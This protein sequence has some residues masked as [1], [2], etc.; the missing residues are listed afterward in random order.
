MNLTRRALLRR[1]AGAAG[2]SAA[3]LLYAGHPSFARGLGQPPE[4]F[5]LPVGDLDGVSPVLV[6]ARPFVL[7]GVSWH[8]PA[9]AGIELRS[10]PVGGR[11]S[12]WVSATARGHDGDG[13]PSRPGQFGEP[14]WTGV[15]DAIQVRSDRPVDGLIVHCVAP[16]RRSVWEAAASSE[17][18]I[19]GIGREPLARPTLPTAGGQPPIIARSAWAGN[20]GPAFPPV[21]GA[22]HLAFVHHTVNPNGYAAADVPAMLLAIYQFHR[23]VRGWNDIGYNFLIDAYGRVWEGRAGGID[24]PVIG[25]QAGGYNLESTGVAMLGTFDSVLPSVVAQATLAQL[26]SWKLSLH[27]APV[28]GRVTV[29][30]DPTDAFYTPFAPGALVALPRIAGHRDGCSTGCPGNALYAHL[31]TIRT[32]ARTLTRQASALTLAG[33]GGARTAANDLALAGVTV[34]AGKPLSVS[35]RLVALAGEPLAT[36]PI[37]VQSITVDSAGVA[38]DRTVAQ[39]Q[40]AIDGTWS[41]T[42]MPTENLLLRAVHPV[43]PASVSA[44]LSVGVQPALTLTP[45]PYAPSPATGRVPLTGTIDPQKQSVEIL[46]HRVGSPRASASMKTVSVHGRQ[47][48]VTL[49]CGP[50][51]TG[52]G[53]RRRPTPGRSRAARGR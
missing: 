3:S 48:A 40:T 42:V 4:L 33:A 14:L 30:V 22:V 44:L 53:R 11:F 39:A 41:A 9:N 23:Y 50:A 2:V 8:A 24:L 31:P 38:S 51:P 5:Q 19:V 36:A 34:T 16:T 7:A 1:A 45:V 28:M 46:V 13:P 35:G 43:A 15:A 49:R 52:S 12:P 21:Y 25:A 10:R 26:L 29:E 20:A 27:G 17:A 47:F 32:S 37:V 18:A 6:A